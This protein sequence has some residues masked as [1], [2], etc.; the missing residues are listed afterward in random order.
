M[1]Q[2]L[3]DELRY[4]VYAAEL[5]TLHIGATLWQEN[6]DNCPNCRIFT[7]SQTAGTSICQPWRQSRQTLIRPI[8]DLID[9]LTAQD[10]RR[11]LEVIWISGHHGIAGNEHVEQAALDP[12]ISKP[13]YHVPLK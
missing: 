5:T 13:F 4:N 7:D 12:T 2:H 8:I 1:Y 11:Q 10:P 9:D 3:G 6:Q